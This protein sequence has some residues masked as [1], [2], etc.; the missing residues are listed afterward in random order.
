MPDV[1]TDMTKTVYLRHTLEEFEIMS[2]VYLAHESQMRGGDPAPACRHEML[3]TIYRLLYDEW[4][5]SCR[6][7]LGND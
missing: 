4:D 2:N 7:E 6:E 5:K 3:S 1:H